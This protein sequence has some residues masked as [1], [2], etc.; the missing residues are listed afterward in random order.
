MLEIKKLYYRYHGGHSYALEDISYKFEAGKLY[1]ITGESGAG[2]TT[3]LMLL[4]KLLVPSQGEVLIGGTDISKINSDKLRSSLVNVIFQNYNLILHLNAIDNIN[5][6]IHFSNGLN[7]KEAS[8][9]AY[10][11]LDEV[12]I[13]REKAIRRVDNLSGGEMQRVAIARAMCLSAPILLADEPT[14]NLDQYNRDKIFELLSETARKMN[15]CVIV[16]SHDPMINEI[17]NETLELSDGH[18]KCV[19]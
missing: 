16:V 19:I 2:K 3:L 12:G 15:K 10:K 11:A 6:A 1:G 13:S 9:L 4:A 18:I 17:A 14:G 7:R 5:L 8:K